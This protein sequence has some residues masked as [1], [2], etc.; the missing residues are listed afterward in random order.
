[1]IYCVDP[2]TQYHSWMYIRKSLLSIGFSHRNSNTKVNS[3]RSNSYYTKQN[4]FRHQEL[5]SYKSRS[6]NRHWKSI[7]YGGLDIF[8]G[9]LKRL[10]MVQY[11]FPR[12]SYC[13]NNPK[14]LYKQRDRSLIHFSYQERQGCPLS[15]YLLSLATETLAS[16]I[17]THGS[18]RGIEMDGDVIPLYAD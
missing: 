12:M 5:E 2:F 3:L 15:N 16:I 18:I 14:H 8:G 9:C 11:L 1:M 4:V 10:V 6:I 13:T 17:T 7:R